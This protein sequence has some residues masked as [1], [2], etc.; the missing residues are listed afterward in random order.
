MTAEKENRLLGIARI[1]S[2]FMQAATTMVV[3]IYCAFL[4]S[5]IKPAFDSS[6][7]HFS[8]FFILFAALTLFVSL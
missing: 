2:G 3:V 5:L 7:E 1:V 4:I 6:P 8:L